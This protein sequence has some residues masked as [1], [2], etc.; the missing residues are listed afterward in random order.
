MGAAPPALD[1]VFGLSTVRPRV[2]PTLNLRMITKTVFYGP[3]Q[4]VSTSRMLA[5][6]I[7]RFVRWYM[8]IAKGNRQ[9]SG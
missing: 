9:S 6:E 7:T 1:C 3:T 5:S 8:F 4:S 2:H